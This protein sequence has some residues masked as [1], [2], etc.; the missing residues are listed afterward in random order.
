MDIDHPPDPG[1]TPGLGNSPPVFTQ[2]QSQQDEHTA[3]V[4]SRKRHGDDIIVVSSNKKTVTNIENASASIQ[5]VYVDPSFENTRLYRQED[6]GPFIVHLSRAEPDPAAGLTLRP[7][8]VGLLL[9]KNNVTHIARD[10]IKSLG[11]NR[12]SIEFTNADAANKFLDLS[13]LPA[14]KYKA[15]IPTFN[16]SRMG[17]IRGIPTDWSMEELVLAL[18]LPEGCGRVMKA[19]RLNRKKSADGT[20]EWIPTQ[21][22]VLT[23]DGQY[24][25]KHVYCFNTSLVVE[26]YQLPTIQCHN[27]CRF[28]HI[29]TQCRSKPRCYKCAQN[30]SGDTCN[31][32]ADKASCLSCS[33]Y[34][35]AINPVCLEHSRQKAIK[36]TMSEQNVS[37]AEAASQHPNV[38]RSYA[39]VASALFAPA[40]SQEIPSPSTY[41]LPSS[42]RSY[43]KT[44]TKTPR[45][46]APPSPGY[47][48]RAHQAIVGNM[49]SPLPNGY[50]LQNCVSKLVCSDGV[51]T[52][53]NQTVSP[54]DNLVEILILLLN[55]I[56]LKFNDALPSNVAEKILQLASLVTNKDGSAAV[57]SVEL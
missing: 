16:I 54:N 6:R 20:I 49:P 44:I 17:L 4:N 28:G 15:T 19:R 3:Q 50:A 31:V 43:R 11:R 37:Y 41:Q 40:Q 26:T 55:N 27:C 33:G 24:L 45:P 18:E 21:S 36:I 38:R 13:C 5:N 8:K 23:F 35:F 51:N 9:S 12:V 47:D 34:H 48:Q 29:K 57:S 53:N 32:E 52:I 10:G 56:L 7:L 2:S 22:V 39:D 42:S 1:D 30:H 46:R 25:P 14:N